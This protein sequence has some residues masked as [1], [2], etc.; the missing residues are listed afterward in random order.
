MKKSNF[1]FVMWVGILSASACSGARQSKVDTPASSAQ[2]DVGS[3]SS[4]NSMAERE[5]ISSVTSDHKTPAP[6][7][8]VAALLIDAPPSIVEQF[9]KHSF[10]RTVPWV[11]SEKPAESEW[12]D[13]TRFLS[14]WL[15]PGENVIR[16]QEMMRYVSRLVSQNI[17]A[18]YRLRVIETGTNSAAVSLEGWRLTPTVKTATPVYEKNV[19]LDAAV[20]VVLRQ[21]ESVL[22][23]TATDK[24]GQHVKRNEK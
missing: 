1:I 14:G 20:S 9:D 21:V 8:K 18:L 12:A 11:T 17:H 5:D 15:S 19:G 2:T 10:I 4:Q 22:E 16:S 6:T 7:E 24:D 3:E 23:D 13:A